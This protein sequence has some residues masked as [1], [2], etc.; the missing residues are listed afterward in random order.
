MSTQVLSEALDYARDNGVIVVAA[1]GNASKSTAYFPASHSAVIG[2]G[3]VT[4]DG[5]LS[6]Y[7]NYGTALDYTTLGNI[8]S[9]LPGSMGSYGSLVGT[10]QSTAVFSGILARLLAHS[11]E[12]DASSLNGLLQSAAEFGSNKSFSKGYG[13]LDINYLLAEYNLEPKK[14]SYIFSN[15]GHNTVINNVLTVPN[16]VRSDSTTLYFNSTESGL[17]MRVMLYNLTGNILLEE[18]HLTTVGVNTITL[19][20]SGYQNGMYL[21]VLK[22]EGS[23]DI[24]TGK[25]VVLR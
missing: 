2:V 14:S 23:S 18:Q 7:S 4:E 12:L 21:Y 17:L 22:G 1:V 16:P 24:Q 15:D 8:Y 19:D 3:S 13:S 10:S 6:S 9:T 20:L 11:P 5:D 25:C